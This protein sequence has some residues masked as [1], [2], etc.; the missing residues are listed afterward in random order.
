MDNKDDKFYID[1]ALNE[2]NMIINY[3]NNKTYLEFVNDIQALDAT[4]FRL[5]QLIEH[6]KNISQEYKSIHSTIPWGNIM[7]FR[8]GIVHSYGKTD[9]TTVYE[10]VTKDIYELKIVFEKK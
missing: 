2:I 9:Y 1:R 4:M 7:G 8:N 6:I 5:I 10:I 3:T